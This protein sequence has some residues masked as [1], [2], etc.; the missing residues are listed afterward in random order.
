MLLALRVFRRQVANA[1]GDMLLKEQ[2]MSKNALKVTVISAA[3]LAAVSFGGSAMAATTS[4]L[5]MAVGTAGEAPAASAPSP[6]NKIPAPTIDTNKDGKA[7]A[8]DRDA[9]GKPDAWDINGDGKPDQLDNDGDGK[10][11]GE[12][13]LPSA[14]PEETSE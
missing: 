11:D 14:K 5:A 3:T 6:E 4:P 8:W 1:T 2:L 7:D 9:N 12:T 13:G 10:P